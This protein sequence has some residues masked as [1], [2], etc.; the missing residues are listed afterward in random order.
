MSETINKRIPKVKP[1]SEILPKGVEGGKEFARIVDFL[2][3]HE[4]RRTGKKITLFDDASGDYYGLDSFEGERS[5]RHRI[6]GYQYKFYSS[7]L[8]D[9]HRGEI[10]KSLQQTAENQ[11]KLNL[12]KWILVTPD[13]LMNAPNR[14]GGGDVVWFEK[15][16]E[17]LDIGFELEHMGHTKLISLFMQTPAICLFYYPELVGGGTVRRKTITD[18]RKR[19]DDNLKT[20]Y[21]NIE[22][23]GMSVYKQETVRGVPM[24]NIYIPL[25]ALPEGADE[26]DPN[27]VRVNPLDFLAPGSRQVVLGDPGSGKST[28]LKFLALVGQSPAIQKRCEAKPDDRLPVFIT[29]RRYAD[30]LKSRKNL[31]LIDY[32]QESIQGDFNLKDADMDFFEFYLESSRTI[33][34][35]DG[36]NELPDPQF[37]KDM[38]NRIRA[39]LTTYPGNTAVVSSRIVGYDGP[40]RFDDKEF[41]HYRLTKFRLPE[42]ERFVNDWY[43]ARVKNKKQR[44]T[45]A[46]DLIRILQDKGH[47]AILELGQNPMLLII[48]SLVHRIDAVLPDERVVL[49]QKCTET[50]LNTWHT[51]KYRDT[52]TRHR[53]KVERRNRRRMEAIAHWM[54]CRSAGSGKEQ[55]FVAPYN[56]LK[57]F[58]TEHIHKTEK[59]WN[60]AEDI[61]EMA[62]E[63]LEFVEKRA[64]LLIEI[65]DNRYSFVHLTFQEYLTASYIKTVHEKDDVMEI[66]KRIRKY[67]YNPRWV[68]V[69]RLLIGHLESDETQEFLINHFLAHPTKRQHF[70][71]SLLLGG[72]LLDGIEPAEFRKRDIF[73]QILQ[74]AVT[75]SKKDQLND[76]LAILNTCLEKD[77]NNIVEME[78]AFQLLWQTLYTQ[79]KRTA[80]VLTVVLLG[81]PEDTINRLTGDFLSEP[82]P[83]TAAYRLFFTRKPGGKY[84]KYLEEDIEFLSAVQDYL[85]MSSEYG[86]FVAAVLQ[87][88]PVSWGETIYAD[89]AFQKQLTVLGL[90]ASSIHF[91]YLNVYYLFV[92]KDNT[93]NLHKLALDLDLKLARARALDRALDRARALEQ[94]RIRAR[95]RAR[96]P[97]LDMDMDLALSLVRQKSPEDFWSAMQ[98][99]LDLC[100][101]LLDLLC[102]IFGLSPE[103]HWQEALRIGFLPEVPKRLRLFDQSRWQKVERA[104]TVN[105]FSETDIYW[106]AWQLLFDC[107]FYMYGYHNSP[108]ES[109]VQQLAQL[110]AGIDEPPLRIAHCVRDLAYGD[111]SRTHDLD[112]M[113]RSTDPRYR[114]IFDRSLW[115]PID[116]TDDGGMSILPSLS[117]GGRSEINYPESPNKPEDI[118]RKI[119]ISYS[120]MDK[121]RVNR[122]VI[123]LEDNNLNVW[124][125][126]KKIK[127]GDSITRKVEQGISEC[128]FFCLVLSKHS[129]D[130]KWVDLEYRTAQNIRLTTGINLKI[131]PILIQDVELPPFLKDIKY[132]DFSKGYKSGFS[133]LLDG[134]KKD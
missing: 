20:L 37:K 1:L 93:V 103:T 117:L 95:T 30:E 125:D 131:L 86:S 71:K 19:Y 81:W 123:D 127:V 76:L 66:W 55:R 98:T 10:K 99:D 25:S 62:V 26:S 57:D 112:A 78:R 45:H 13:D 63:F 92:K 108:T 100:D 118:M 90:G 31:S 74:S 80:S 101:P 107:W 15:L 12:K 4:A 59:Y 44:D 7:P 84:S 97:K 52:E 67:Q 54:H 96:T 130:S 42:M 105:S 40:F 41:R 35:F 3:F 91:Y 18:I 48:I 38:T 126:E 27:T 121:K 128:D 77:H 60:V 53:G 14:K 106:V 134:I 61:E 5:W 21:G 85:P 65:G 116:N 122:L 58:L 83:A 132:A 111:K 110:T 120:H 23:V 119:F 46:G 6:T 24:E 64:G 104:F 73:F 70:L 113:V 49:Y 22:F 17:K 88:V 82:N 34:L 8:S 109:P 33:L 89:K 16:K 36:L 79:K 32:I 69:I 94:V 129:V 47:K 56:D 9:R 43:A 68:E 124:R 11:K 29:L 75:V 115:I 2:L 28:L 114:E 50:L 51:W 102:K 39:L 87:A 133:E 72:I